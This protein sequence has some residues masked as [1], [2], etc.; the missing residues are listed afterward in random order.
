MINK[1]RGVLTGLVPIVVAS[2]LASIAMAPAHAQ[3]VPAQAEAV[4][5]LHV[6]GLSY[7][8]D[9]S[10]L[11]IPSHM[12]MA[13]YSGGRWSK[14]GGPPHDYMGFSATHNAFYSSGHPAPGSGLI[15]PFGLLKSQDGG[16]SWQKLGLEG[17][18][19]FH[20]MATSYETNTVY[21]IN[22]ASN[23]QMKQPGVYYTRSDGA[24]WTMAKGDGLSG[25]ANGLAVHPT[26]FR[27]VAAV[28]D[29]GLF[30]SEDAGDHFRQMQSEQGLA[31]WFDL[32]GT[33][34][35]YSHYAGKP[36]L[37]RITWRDG[38]DRQDVALPSLTNDA[39]AFIAQNSV[40]RNEMAIATFQR[41]VY[42]SADQG[43]TWKQIARGGQTR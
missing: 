17:Q 18:A 40:K 4:S 26:N 2:W 24:Q 16:R 38:K 31:A 9:G 10:K 23:D 11:F 5:L 21:V 3:A 25:E 36:A 15:N 7:S 19:D 30:L 35:W 22:H 6:H 29:K 1:P 13:V 20:S 12:G 34:L 41:D 39:V 37:T 32:D 28:T 33:H 8:P 27:V 14:A 43:R 42:V